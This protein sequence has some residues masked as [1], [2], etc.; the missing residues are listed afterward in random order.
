MDSVAR[1][2]DHRDL[3]RRAALT[4][5]AALG[6]AAAV[7]LVA[8]EQ[9]FA[10]TTEY[11][12]NAIDF[13]GVDP[14]GETDS[15][16]G[17]QKAIDKAILEKKPLYLPPGEFLISAGLKAEAADFAI[18]GAGSGVSVI[19][20][21]SSSFDCLTIGPGA[22]GSGDG[23][24]GYARDISFDG[25]SSERGKTGTGST[26]GKAALKLNGMREFEVTNVAV[27]P[28]SEFDIAFELVNDSRG[29]TF[30]NCTAGLNGCRV[31][32]N[33]QEGSGSDVTF[34]NCWLF[35][36]VAAAHL[37]ANVSGYHFF[38]GQMTAS[39][40]S[41]EEEVAEEDQRGSVILG[42]NYLSPGTTGPV[43]SCTFDG[44]DFEFQKSCWIF[45]A[46]AEVAISM[47]D[48]QFNGSESEWFSL[49][50]FKSSAFKNGRLTMLDNRIMGQFRRPLEDLL[51]IEGLEANASIF[52]STTSGDGD[53]NEGTG[54]A[55][56]IPAGE[57]PMTL[58]CKQD[59]AVATTP[60]QL[61]LDGLL[62]RRAFAGLEVSNDWGANW[63]S[64]YPSAG[65]VTSA[66]EISL[67]G[68][69]DFYTVN[70]ATSIKKI[71]PTYA[72][73]IVVLRFVVGVLT[74]E[75]GTG[76][77]VLSSSFKTTAGDT[78]TL[79]CD[80]TSWY[81]VARRLL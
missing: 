6:G 9:A 32:L 34:F 75:S 23:P 45:R 15:T 31:G 10:A 1:N 53:A 27:R 13:E 60:T 58:F 77:L 80:G 70:G 42:R 52:E 48:C 30:H 16:V 19:L 43:T 62:M 65:T 63:S 7:S 61:L 29:C 47:K 68:G 49:G 2:P 4:G 44:I 11:F 17:L 28:D 3:T 22:E 5:A 57:K 24:S 73:H 36:E 40:G 51:T 37:G 81:E 35:G 56:P 69:A 54:P 79:V 72:G 8:A 55:Q 41:K 59:H 66:S 21:E 76:N 64:P 18:F 74:V 39:W 26:T 71:V 38:G 78:L 33:A 50:I 25:G 46:F 14:S 67:A 20:T 12:V